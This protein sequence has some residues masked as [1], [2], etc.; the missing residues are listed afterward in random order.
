MHSAENNNI[1]A[2]ALTHYWLRRFSVTLH[3]ALANSFFK[4]LGR[5]NTRAFREESR[6]AG[7][8]IERGIYS[9]IVAYC[10]LRS[11]MFYN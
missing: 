3:N 1:L 11:N 8:I 9:Y 2:A 5:A 6:D 7:V 4:H 10:S